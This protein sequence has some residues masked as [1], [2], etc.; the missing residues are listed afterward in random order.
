MGKKYWKQCEQCRT[1]YLSDLLNY[2][3]LRKIMFLI[4]DY[5]PN[6]CAEGRFLTFFLN[7]SRDGYHKLAILNP[8]LSFVCI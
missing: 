2:S 1:E 5:N 8:V 4:N 7:F 6:F 3:V